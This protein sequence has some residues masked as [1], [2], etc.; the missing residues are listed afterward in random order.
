MKQLKSWWLYV[1]PDQPAK[2]VA[3]LAAFLVLALLIFGF[4]ASL[5]DSRSELSSEVFYSTSETP[6]GSMVRVEVVS[7]L[8]DSAQSNTG[9][10][11]AVKILEGDRRGQI[12][13][14]EARGGLAEHARVGD[15]MIVWQSSS[16]GLGEQIYDFWRIGGLAILVATLLL[17]VFIVS[18]FRGLMGLYGLFFSLGVIVFWAIPAIGQGGNAFL[19]LIGASFLI[20]TI[21]MLLSHG[22]GKRARVA[23]VALYIS[24]LLVVI[25][26]LVGNYFGKLTGIYDETSSLLTYGVGDL[27][28]HG[29]LLGGIVIA[30][31]GLL[32]D[33][34]ITQV[35]SVE[36]VAKANPSLGWFELFKRGLSVG[37]SHIAS[38]INT[39][40]LAYTGASLPVILSLVYASSGRSLLEVLNTEFMAQEIVRTVVSSIGLVLAV[41]VATWLAAFVYSRTVGKKDIMETFRLRRGSN[42]YSRDT[43]KSKR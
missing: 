1:M 29:V 11:V 13:K 6:S 41:P 18:G 21:S 28:L 42:G 30:S 33:I 12:E 25:L 10:M 8:E 36:Q 24:L 31:L 38:L 39:L 22:F 16:E 43:V 15:T 27:D 17:A 19:I 5:Y 14:L 9:E 37:N 20:A 26:T 2:F 32:D 40:A 4:N 7:L 23:V 34:V 35:A 3:G